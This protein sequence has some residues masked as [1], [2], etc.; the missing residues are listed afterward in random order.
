MGFVLI[1][2]LLLGAV[3][4][5][6]ALVKRAGAR[7]ADELAYARLAARARRRGGADDRG[8]AAERQ[9]PN[10]RISL[11]TGHGG[12]VFAPGMCSIHTSLVL[13]RP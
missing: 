5:E 12:E 1:P 10:A 8:E 13:G 3:I 6:R 7:E 11:V 2:S 9:I 4:L